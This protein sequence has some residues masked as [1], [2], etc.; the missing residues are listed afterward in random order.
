[1]HDALLKDSGKGHNYLDRRLIKGFVYGAGFA[2]VVIGCWWL[3][4]WI[5]DAPRDLVVR[6]ENE[7]KTTLGV[8][9]GVSFGQS[10]QFL[11]IPYAVPPVGERRFEA[12]ELWMTPF[13]GGRFEAGH[14]GPICPQAHV[15]FHLPVN[16]DCLTLNIY[17]PPSPQRV[18]PFP[19]MV[20]LHGGGF[21]QGA[22]H[23]RA[24]DF[25]DYNG[26]N[27]AMRYGA[28]VVT[29]N[30]RLGLLGWTAF[31][32]QASE[33]ISTGNWGLLDQITALKWVQRHI[34]A[35]G[36]DPSRT[37]L[38]GQSAGA[39]STCALLTCPAANGLFQSATLESAHCE[40]LPLADA[41]QQTS[42]IASK[43]GC[44]G[45]NDLKTCL[46][47]VPWA[48]ILEVQLALTTKQVFPV[49]DGVL[50]TDHPYNLAKSGQLSSDVPIM[51]GQNFDAGTW[52]AQQWLGG[53]WFQGP[54]KRK[55]MTSTDF[56]TAVSKYLQHAAPY[57][58]CMANA[59]D[60]VLSWYPASRTE[61]NSQMYAQFYADARYICPCH[62]F[63]EIAAQTT[64]VYVYSFRYRCYPGVKPRD[65]GVYHGAELHYVFGQPSPQCA[66]SGT[67]RYIRELVSGLWYNFASGHNTPPQ[68]P[69]YNAKALANE[70]LTITSEGLGL[71]NQYRKEQCEFWR[72]I[73]I[74]CSA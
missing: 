13:D 5:F 28:V 33:G 56:V 59:L 57:Y 70:V 47:R 53:P 38:F 32:D 46:R 42:V 62:F 50:L 2:T 30:Y 39:I 25:Q 49:Q 41:L 40:A 15:M 52:F 34:A 58:P 54:N 21:V 11:G 45:A 3:Y 71:T 19:V 67:E 27:L 22:S 74:E 14:F 20:F 26:S 55:Y 16:E 65:W 1:M 51:I 63:V 6:W 12:T 61:D 8:I 29:V 18:E 37:H 64:A 17:A 68:W 72:G 9:A 60:K 4:W 7:V 73:M 69:K 24:G 36:G 10:R 43:L 44:S 35:F 31:L 66:N 23:Y 48:N